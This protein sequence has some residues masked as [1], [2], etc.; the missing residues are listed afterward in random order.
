LCSLSFYELSPFSCLD[1]CGAL[2]GTRSPNTTGTVTVKVILALDYWKHS[3]PKT[4][5][6]AALDYGTNS[7]TKIVYRSTLLYSLFVSRLHVIAT[8]SLVA[9]A[10]VEEEGPRDTHIDKVYG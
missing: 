10:P 2:P 7:L 5:W 9:R 6:R 1:L 8:L 4:V 3:L